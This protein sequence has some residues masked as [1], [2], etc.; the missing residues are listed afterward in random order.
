MEIS[1]QQQK[2]DRNFSDLLKGAF[3]KAIFILI[4]SFLVFESA[5]NA[6]T[7]YAGKFWGGAGD[8]WQQIWDVFL[9][10]TGIMTL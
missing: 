1:G 3:F 9:S 8:V 5:R 6:L 4:S 7:W 10:F 2:H